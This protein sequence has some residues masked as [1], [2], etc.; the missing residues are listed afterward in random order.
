M[1]NTWYAETNEDRNTTDTSE[2][3]RRE[4]IRMRRHR[5]KHRIF[6]HFEGRYPSLEPRDMHLDII[7]YNSGKYTYASIRNNLYSWKRIEKFDTFILKF[8][9]I[10]F[11]IILLC[12]LFLSLTINYLILL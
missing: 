8:S 5:L 3:I 6:S 2:C 9:K 12:A 4:L 7:R 1:S 11:F 10:D